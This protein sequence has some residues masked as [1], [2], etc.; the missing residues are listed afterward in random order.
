MSVVAGSGQ[1]GATCRALE[2]IDG[3]KEL[4]QSQGCLCSK[5]IET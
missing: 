1:F 3:I 2:E 5:E 4:G